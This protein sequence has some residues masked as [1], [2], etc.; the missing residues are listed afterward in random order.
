MSER[1][2][3]VK[4]FSKY[5]VNNLGVVRELDRIQKVRKGKD[6]IVYGEEVYGYYGADGYEYVTLYRNN[7]RYEVLLH[8]MMLKSFKPTKKKYKPLHVDGDKKNN[9]LDNLIW[10]GLK[11][12]QKRVSKKKVWNKNSKKVYQYDKEGRLVSVWDSLQEVRNVLG[13]GQGNISL[14]ANGKKP[15]AYGY[16]WSYTKKSKG[17]VVNGTKDV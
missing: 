2:T 6:I 11:E 16:I 3:P 12:T 13:Y 17:C 8:E 15:E 9:T 14:V 5:E 1:W 7:K 4:G 10:D